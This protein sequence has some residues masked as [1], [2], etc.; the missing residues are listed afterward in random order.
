MCCRATVIPAQAGIQAITK[1]KPTRMGEKQPAVHILASRRNG[2]LYIGVTA[3][4][5]RRVWEHK[6]NLVEGF[7]GRTGTSS[8]NQPKT[9]QPRAQLPGGSGPQ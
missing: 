9:G 3:D 8:P 6:N 5:I 7:T 1:P 2:T 4:L